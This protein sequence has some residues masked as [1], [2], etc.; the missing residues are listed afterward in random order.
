MADSFHYPPE[1][2]TLMADV[3][4]LL[5]RSKNDVVLFFRGAGVSTTELSPIQAKLRA[6]SSSINKYQIS[7]TVLES[8]NA[9]GDSGLAVRR[10]LLKRVVEFEDFTS[11]WPDDQ[12]K[13]K[14]MVADLKKIVNV[15]DSFTRMKQEREYDRSE[16]AEKKRIEQAAEAERRRKVDGAEKSLATL[17][18]MDDK[19][20]ERGKQLEK[21][22][23]DLFRA[24]GILVRE[25]FRRKDPDCSTVVEQVDGVIEVDGIIHL[26]EM[27]WLNTPVG[28]AE[29]SQHL[30]RL[31][32]RANAHGIFISSS[33][34]TEPVLK[35]SANFL[36]LKTMYLCS[37]REI[38][39]LLQRQGDLLEFL[40]KK[41]RAA[42][43]E[44][45]PY[46]EILS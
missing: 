9:K 3:I 22:L 13:A 43:V 37:L 16:I 25:D 26:V 4:P 38:V 8:V 12:F 7:R 15:K 5:C 35:E 18:A 23:N 36:N 45:N 31:F 29:F 41:S 42:I 39:M 11:C 20:H 17:F 14:G 34:Y 44:K 6:D 30:V 40:R 1:V 19:P 24:Y 27:K 21:V 33:S 10:E 46:L 32:G 28:M 2:F